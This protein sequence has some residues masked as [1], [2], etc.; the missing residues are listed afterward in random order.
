MKTTLIALLIILLYFPV[1]S[2]TAFGIKGGVNFS[3]LNTDS[4]FGYQVEFGW[5]GGVMGKKYLGDLG[6]FLQ[7]EVLYQQQG[8]QNHHLDYLKIPVMVGFDFSD[9]L[10]IHFGWYYGNL[11][12]SNENF[13][14]DDW[15]MLLGMDFYTTKSFITTIRLDHGFHNIVADEATLNFFNAKNAVIDIS[16]TYLLNKKKE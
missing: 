2:Q 15:G 16:I 6:Y 5:H 13:K 8:N 14:S 11:L 12:T 9:D 1:F 4:N 7:G 3:G 10:N